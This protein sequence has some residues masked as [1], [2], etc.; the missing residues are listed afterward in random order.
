MITVVVAT[1]GGEHWIDLA[2]KRAIPSAEPQAPVIHHH[3]DTL[4]AARNGGL[5]QIESE[6]VVFL[7]ADDRLEDGYVEA[8]QQGTADLRVP[9]L[10]QVRRNG[11]R[12]GQPFMPQVW[13]HRHACAAECLRQGNWIVIG[14]AVRTELLRSVGGFEEWGW[15][16][17]WAAFAR[18]WKAGGTVEVIPGAIY[19]AWVRPESRNHSPDHATIMRWHRQ[20][21]RA[22]WPED[23]EDVAA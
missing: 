8:M 19:R 12:I 16:E 22:V 6:F 7:D 2:K 21:E 23:F 10:R 13:G 5:A 1:Y 4:A 15:S 17:D 3:A 11:R 14:A 20:I 9:M 18:C